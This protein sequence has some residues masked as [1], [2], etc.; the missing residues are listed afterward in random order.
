M[1]VSL[2][3]PIYGAES[4]LQKNLEEISQALVKAPESWELLLVIDSSP[5]RSVEICR[6]FAAQQKS[7]PVKVLI[8]KTN[9][10][11]GATVRKG[12][13]EATGQYRIFT[14][15]DLA[16]PVSEVMKVLEVL[17]KGVEVAIASRAHPDTRY[18]VSPDVCRNLYKRHLMSRLFSSLVR[19][20]SLIPNCQD[21]Q[22]GLKGFTAEAATF[23]F[24]QAKLDGFS[25]DVELLYLATR[26]RFS[27]QEVPVIFYYD[28]ASSM[29]FLKDGLQMFLDILKI[30]FWNFQGR[31]QFHGKNKT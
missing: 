9:F 5:D 24:S 29:K 3:V 28:S 21:T 17:K 25:F 23:L 26:R 8:N 2:I 30:H 18:I 31:Y 6:E 1:D 27:I 16:Y 4:F 13:L 7:F 11:K 19:Y 15:C 14:D 12:M 22:A 20:T 10:G